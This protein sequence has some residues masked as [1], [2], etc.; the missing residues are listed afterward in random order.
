MPYSL[1]FKLKQHTPLIHFQA[2]DPDATLRAT[3]VKP[4]LDA[5][6]IEK[7]TLKHCK[8]NSWLVG[9]GEHP[10][11][12]FKMH[13]TICERGSEETRKGFPVIIPPEKKKSIKD[14]FLIK[15]QQQSISK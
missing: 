8:Q 6:L 14:N 3:E 10:A 12:D 1:E 11:L 9:N 4:K 13:I 15:N 7:L 5:F 2:D